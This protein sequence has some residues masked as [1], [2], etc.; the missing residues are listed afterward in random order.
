MAI[1][2]KRPVLYGY[3]PQ[4]KEYA[5][6][7]RPDIDAASLGRDVLDFLI[8][9]FTTDVEPPDVPRGSVAVWRG[10]QWEIVA[11]HRGQTWWQGEIPVRI[12][13]L[14]DP[15]GAGLT[16]D[17]PE[18]PPPPPEDPKEVIRRELTDRLNRIT[19]QGA[20]FVALKQD[21]PSEIIAEHRAIVTDLRAL[22]EKQ[23]V[24]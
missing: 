1:T 2:F 21:V 11:D 13:D 8:P 4:T 6:P 19:T 5:G 18:P 20:S 10:D 12:A 23:A 3:D 22:D 24:R 7:A 15:A 14:G 9:A 16:K 17:K